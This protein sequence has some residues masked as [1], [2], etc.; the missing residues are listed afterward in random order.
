MQ[1]SP[2]SSPSK[3]WRRR[4]SALF[5]PPLSSSR[6]QSADD[7]PTLRGSGLAGRDPPTLTPPL[8][9]HAERPVP[10]RAASGPPVDVFG[11]AIPLP[12]TP[13]PP[14]SEA[15]TAPPMDRVHTA[16]LEGYIVEEPAV[17]PRTGAI[18]LPAVEDNAIAAGGV[19][20]SAAFMVPETQEPVDDDALQISPATVAPVA[21]SAQA[22]E[23][24]ALK[25][26][27]P[28]VA[29]H[30]VVKDPVGL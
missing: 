24:D 27:G 21:A 23:H 7:V 6:Q 26:N 15:L 28:I 14:R 25:A 1:S 17:P 12:A 8:L 30:T 29:D 19:A 11:T 2:P 3:N 22:G 5:A 13:P 10:A 20:A 16:E 4:A 9:E 18:A